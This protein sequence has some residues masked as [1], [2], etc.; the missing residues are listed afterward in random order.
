L[1]LDSV[2]LTPPLL[3]N[4]HACGLG[5]KLPA[6]HQAT[7]VLNEQRLASC[8]PCTPCAPLSAG[9]FREWCAQQMRALSGSDDVTLCEFL[10]TVEAN[11]EVAEYITMYLGSS[12]AVSA[13]SVL[14]CARWTGL[15][16]AGLVDKCA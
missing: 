6:R 7:E 4:T 5:S 15:C 11:S 2:L 13:L 8:A 12:P 1:Y 14:R 16:G 10:L 9:A 3:I